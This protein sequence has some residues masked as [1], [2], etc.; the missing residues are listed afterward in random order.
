MPVRVDKISVDFDPYTETVN[1]ATRNCYRC[2][3]IKDFDCFKRLLLRW[4]AFLLLC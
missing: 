2:K 1:V 3:Q 4:L